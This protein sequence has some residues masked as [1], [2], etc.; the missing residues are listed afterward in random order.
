MGGNPVRDM[1]FPIGGPLELSVCLQLFL[2]YWANGHKHIG[3]A[4]EPCYHVISHATIRFAI[5][6]FLLVVPNLEHS[7]THAESSLELRG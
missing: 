5:G 6:H 1:P 2:G 4:T 7:Q 3:V